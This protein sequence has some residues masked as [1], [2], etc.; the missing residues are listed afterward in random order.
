MFDILFTRAA[1]GHLYLV[2]LISGLGW[3]LGLAA[4][5]LVA[6]FLERR[7]AGGKEVRS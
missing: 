4:L 1:D 5:A 3:T 6:R 2:W 7:M